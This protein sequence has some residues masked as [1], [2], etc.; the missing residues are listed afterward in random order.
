MLMIILVQFFETQFHVLRTLKVYNY[1]LP[2][3]YSGR[4]FF[5]FLVGVTGIHS[6][7]CF[8]SDN[9]PSWWPKDVV[10]SPV[11]GIIVIVRSTHSHTDVFKFCYYYACHFGCFF[12]GPK[13]SLLHVR[14]KFW[15]LF[16]RIVRSST[17]CK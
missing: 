6:R 1:Y 12:G 17:Q 5:D 14:E 11:R 13:V 7:E 8:K 16:W 15:Q 4:N 10:F 2:N 3:N 9:C